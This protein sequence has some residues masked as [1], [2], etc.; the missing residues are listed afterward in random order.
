MILLQHQTS[1]TSRFGMPSEEELEAAHKKAL[2]SLEG[3][4]RSAI[5]K[6]KG[7]KGKKAKQAIAAVEEE[8][9]S[10]LRDMQQEHEQKLKS[11]GALIES[12][13]NQKKEGVVASELDD[14]TKELS[15]KEKKQLKARKKKERQKEREIERQAALD[16]EIA[17]AGP[18]LRDVELEQIEITL[19]PLDLCMKEVEAD[20]HCLYRAIGAQ[21]G[22]DYQ[23][24]RGICADALRDNEPEF[25]PFCELTDAV[26][27]FDSYVSQVRN[28]AEWGGHLELRA[29]S[30]ALERPIHVFS[31]QSGTKPLEIDGGSGKG[32]E[33]LLLS[34]HLHYYALERR[35][36]W[37]HCFR[38]N[39]IFLIQPTV[40]TLLL[41]KPSIPSGEK[42]PCSRPQTKTFEVEAFLCVLASH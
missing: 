10:R 30:L 16:S 5:K 42:M 17:N 3:E 31:V 29:L 37:F 28:S 15:E 19:T 9:A 36:L 27:S 32:K 40:I 25:S 20:G 38:Y 2:K 34:Y 13:P 6:A 26:S 23:E 7:T 11:L 35:L 21:M 4:K 12:P 41:S 39:N 8:Y 24:I 14:T 1:S 22:T 18:S 33:P